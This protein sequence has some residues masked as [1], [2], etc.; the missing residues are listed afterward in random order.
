MTT[1]IEVSELQAKFSERTSMFVH[2]ESFETRAEVAPAA[3]R[4]SGGRMEVWTFRSAGRAPSSQD[5]WA[6]HQ[7]VSLL[8]ADDPVQLASTMLACAQRMEELAATGDVVVDITAFRREELLVMM[9]MLHHVR[10][11]GAGCYF[12]YVPAKA[13]SPDWLSRGVVECRSVVGFPGSP[14]PGRPDHLVLMLGFELDRARA[15]IEYYEPARVS[16]GAG[17]P[18]GSISPEFY[19]RNVEVF[20]AFLAYALPSGTSLFEF[21]PDDPLATLR[22]LR[23]LLDVNPAYNQIIAPLNNKVTTI[24]A[25]LVALERPDVQIVYAPAA[26]YNE[27]DY[28]TPGETALVFSAS[29]LFASIA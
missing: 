28:S 27:G 6:G 24:G 23:I 7:V 14:V 18:D 9:R 8:H 10:R 22:A 29:D 17:S 5:A 1:K 13:Y 2:R 12:L 11:S 20:D 26:A 25:A 15:L 16:L 4:G 3:F 21:A 19:R